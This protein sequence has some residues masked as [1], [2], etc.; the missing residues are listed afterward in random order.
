MDQVPRSELVNFDLDRLNGS[1]Q[2]RRA[3][4]KETL[5]L[6]DGQEIE[7]RDDTLV[8]ADE[9]SALAIAGVMGGQDSGV[10][11]STTN[12]FLECAYPHII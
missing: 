9:N 6:L 1:I 3:N 8:I 4:D 10:N 7:L 11:D 12:I 2:V 5:T